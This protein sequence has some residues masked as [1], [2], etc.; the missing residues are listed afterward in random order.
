MDEK[1]IGK[2]TIHDTII[3]AQKHYQYPYNQLGQT[4]WHVSQVGFGTYRVS[5]GTPAH[6]EALRYALQSGINLVDTSSNYTDGRSEQLIGEVVGELIADGFITRQAIIIVSK[7][8]Y[9]QGKNYHLSQAWKQSGHPLPD[10]VEYAEGL[11]YCIHPDF[12][13]DQLR[14]SRIRLNMETIDIYLLHNPEYYLDWANKQGLDLVTTQ[15]EYYRRIE[16]AF[17]YLETAVSEGFIQ[18]Y[19]VSSNTFP[20]S[21]NDP[22]FTSLARIWQIA[23]SITPNHHF[24]VI[25]LPMNLYEAEG[26]IEKNLPGN[27]SV[28]DFAQDKQIGVLINRPLNAFS[29]NTLVR[30]ADVPPPAY[31]A[32]NREVSTVVDTLVAWE[33][34][35]QRQILPHLSLNK[36]EGNLVLSLLAVGRSLQ[37]HWRGLGSYQNWNDLRAQYLIPRA[38]Q[39]LQFLAQQEE[40]PPAYD[41]WQANYVEA[42]NN[43]LAA[44]SAIYQKQAAEEGQ[45]LLAEVGKINAEWVAQTLSQT[46][47]R[48]LRS[49]SAVSSVLVGMRRKAY[50]DDM[51]A[52]LVHPLSIQNQ[53]DAWKQ[54]AFQTHWHRS[55]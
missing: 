45:R 50:V 14:R 12:L 10:L 23:E 44:I 27:Q 34:A 13:Q 37:T 9:L 24:R 55:Q 32:S 2:T 43:A 49:T 46:A 25:Q 11:E 39:A 28:L 7:V 40:M 36:E 35:F 22:Q 19:G 42:V 21:S 30:L 52:D 16:L 47:V 5:Q 8:G 6:T 1:I 15:T 33:V 41:E 4:G 38:H 29:H 54:I 3:Y 31:P 18:Y 17:R 51:L 48:A 53:D 26:A 20:S